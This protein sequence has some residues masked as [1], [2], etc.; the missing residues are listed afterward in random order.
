MGADTAKPSA[1]EVKAQKDAEREAKAKEAQAQKEAKAK[2]AAEAKARKAQEA[3]E[4]KLKRQAEQVA[5]ILSEGGVEKGS[6]HFPKPADKGTPI[7]VAQA[8]DAVK[9]LKAEE[10]ANRP[11]KASLTLSQRRAMLNLAE[12]GESGVVPKTGFN[13]LPLQHL[14]D[15]GLA[16]SFETK[17]TKPKVETVEK[18]VEIPEAERKEGGP[19]TRTVKEK[20]EST[21]TVKATGFRLTESG[22]ARSGEINPKWKNWKPTAAPVEAT[23]EEAKA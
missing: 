22:M 18:E 3:S 16:E 14:V 12:A 2:E 19:T 8:R 11:K 6:S 4:A 5:K 20:V 7:T 23:P 10:R 21:E 1:E 9:A 15:V 17:T 13:A